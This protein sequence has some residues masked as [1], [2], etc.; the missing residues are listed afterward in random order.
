MGEVC[1]SPAHAAADGSDRDALQDGD[2]DVI[3]HRVKPLIKGALR[4][5]LLCTDSWLQRDHVG[6]IE[7][8]GARRKGNLQHAV[9]GQTEQSVK[10]RGFKLMAADFILDEHLNVYLLSF[11]D[12]PELHV[13]QSKVSYLL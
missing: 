10:R 8:S 1:K 3:E 9:A 5:S 12:N 2:V 6:T 4:H 11:C 13:P 7:N